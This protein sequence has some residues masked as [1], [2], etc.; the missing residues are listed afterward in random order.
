MEG[1]GPYCFK[2]WGSRTPINVFEGNATLVQQFYVWFSV[3]WNLGNLIGL[4]FFSPEGWW[5][6]YSGKNLSI[7]K[8]K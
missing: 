4:F 7:G 6:P 5:Y 2:S 8:K 3:L 1:A